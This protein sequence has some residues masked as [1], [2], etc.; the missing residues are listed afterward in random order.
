MEKQ[1]YQDI[2]KSIYKWR[3]NNIEMYREIQKGYQKANYEKYKDSVLERKKKQYA[4]KKEMDIFR[5]I[6]LN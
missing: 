2:K 5:K 1:T 6:L 4:I 3:E